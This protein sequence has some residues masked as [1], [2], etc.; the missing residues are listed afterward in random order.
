MK[1]LRNRI[2]S[3]LCVIAI[4]LLA[5]CG[6][7][8]TTA[9]NGETTAAEAKPTKTINIAYQ[10]GIGYA[11]IHVM[12]TKNLIEKNYPGEIKVTFQKLDSGAAI[13]E[14][15]IGGSIQIGCMGVAPAVSG[16]AAGIPYK[17]VSG[18]CAQSHGLMSN[19]PEIRTLADIKDT[20][21]IALVNTGSIQHILLAMTAEKVLGDAHALDN[22]IQKMSHA[23]G[24]A[25]LESGTVQLHLTSSPFIYQE[26]AN[27][28]YNEL[29]EL[30]EVWPVGNTFLVAMASE[31]ISEDQELFQAVKKAFDE[32][33]RFINE[34]RKGIVEIE[35]RYLGLEPEEVE[36]DL[37]Q[38]ECQFSAELKGV[39]DMADFMYRAGFIE[40]EMKAEDLMF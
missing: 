17:I 15:I 18:L 28:R 38:P 20:D 34:D 32:A 12:E 10:G 6:A 8:N 22:N 40:K 1:M 4:M 3:V 33:I 29:T 37:N 7:Q 25:A 21:K 31:S 11:P 39:Q 23:E 26:R 14:G 5:G 30:N 36:A 35:S 24:M 2:L 19:N 16:A 13:N 27:E 9:K